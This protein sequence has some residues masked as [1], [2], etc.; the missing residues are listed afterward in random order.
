MRKYLGI[1][2]L[3]ATLLPV[4]AAIAMPAVSATTGITCTKLT[5]TATWS[6][7][8]P[9]LGS[10]KKVKSTVKASGKVSGCTGTKG[11]SNGTFSFLSKPTTPG[12]CATLISSKKAST[13]SSSIK[14]NNKKTSTS[15]KVTLTPAGTATEK[16]TGKISGGTQFKGKSVTATVVF[17]PQNGGC[18]SKDL[19]KA[20][21]ALKKST[22]FVIK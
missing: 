8:Q 22:K 14:W 3:V 5:G 2:L 21:L 7:A 19:S 11:I 10:T 15:A 6:P 20:S 17:T 16:V 1:G 4:G 12:N 18:Q 9:K 13:A